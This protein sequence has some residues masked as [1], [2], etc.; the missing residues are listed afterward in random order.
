MIIQHHDY[1]YLTLLNHIIENGNDKQDRTGTG[2]KSIFDYTMRFDLRD[3]TIPLLTTK[4]L[5][6]H[7][8]IH[9]LLWFLSGDTN[10]GYLKQNNVSIWNEWADEAGDLGPIYGQ[11]WR[12]WSSYEFEAYG[13]ATSEGNVFKES[14][15]DQI[16]TLVEGLKTNPDSRRHIVS[17]WNVA[18]LPYMSLP[19]CHAFFQCYVVNGELSLKLTQRS[20]DVFLGVPY[21][22]AQ[23]SILVHML[24]QVCNLKPGYFIWSG[25]DVHLYNNHLDQVEQQLSRCPLPSPKLIINPSIDDIFKFRRDDFAVEGYDNVHPNIPA[26]VAV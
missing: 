26:P 16:A 18:D 17:A 9:E 14:S 11:Q 22:I 23:Y 25:G 24:A 3:G 4:K 6:L 10:I 5:H 21:N 12:N 20:A 2:T 13:D 15:I 7:G 1:Q 8:I 19:P